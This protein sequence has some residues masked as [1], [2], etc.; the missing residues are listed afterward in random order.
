MAAVARRRGEQRAKLRAC[1]AV[2]EEEDEEARGRKAGGGG[3]T[4]KGKRWW[5]RQDSRAVG[6]Q[7]VRAAEGWGR[8]RDRRAD[9]RGKPADA[10]GRSLFRPIP[11]LFPRRHHLEK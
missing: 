11:F 10:D 4:E 8:E 6:C 5:A 9:S 1:D 2:V 7:I 3:E